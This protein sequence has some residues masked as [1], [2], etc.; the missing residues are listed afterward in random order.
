VGGPVTDEHRRMEKS[1]PAIHFENHQPS[2][3]PYYQ[4]ATLVIGAGRV[5]LEAMKLKKPVI[6]I[7]E[8]TYVGPLRV[9]NIEKAKATNLGIVLRPSL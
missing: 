9:A 3:K 1:Q 7:G 6:A 5:A 8:R 4:K 2:L